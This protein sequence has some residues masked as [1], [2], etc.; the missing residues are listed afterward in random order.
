MQI[1]KLA[2]V[3]TT[4]ATAEEHLCVLKVKFIVLGWKQRAYSS[5]QHWGAVTTNVPSARCLMI[6]VSK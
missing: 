3:E 4:Q 2:P 1:A 5:R 6:S